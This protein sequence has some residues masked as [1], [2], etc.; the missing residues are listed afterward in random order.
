MAEQS[1]S[2][3]DATM[4]KTFI[5]FI[6]SNLFFP[7]NS[8]KIPRRLAWTLR[9]FLVNEFNR[10]ATKLATEKP[11]GYINNFLPLPLPEWLSLL[12]ERMLKLIEEVSRKIHEDIRDCIDKIEEN[13]ERVEG[14]VDDLQYK[15]INHCLQCSVDTEKTPPEISSSSTD[16]VEQP[17][18]KL[19][20]LPALLLRFCCA[21]T[22]LLLRLLCAFPAL[23]LHFSNILK[24]YKDPTDVYV[25]H[26]NKE[27]VKRTN[28][29]IIP[30]IHNMYWTLLVGCLK[31]RVWKLF[32]SIGLTEK[33]LLFFDKINKLYIDLKE[34]FDVDISKWRLNIVHGTPTQSNSFDCGM[35]VCK[36]MEKVIVQDKVDWSAYK[37]WQNDMPRYRAEFVYQILRSSER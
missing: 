13:F 31:E 8:H 26:I 35:F 20:R 7:L 37:Y 16:C 21:L 28:L 23:S 2:T 22:V 6:I 14:K 4:L 1:I 3:D 9:E 27:I 24:G 10:M 30:V 25:Q 36:Y 32:L 5:S 33:S 11:L 12:E 34:C 17:L 15:F 19:K 29:L 18:K